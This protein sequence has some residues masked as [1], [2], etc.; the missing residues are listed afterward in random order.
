MRYRPPSK[1][2]LLTTASV[3]L[4]ASL[5]LAFSRP[6]EMRVDG[7]PVVSDVPPVTSVND[8]IFV[9][10][11]PVSDALG[12]ETHYQRKT[13]EVVVTRGDQSLRLRIGSTHA[14]ISGMPITLARAPFRVRG[15]I[16]L[17]LRTVE[18][19]FGVRAKFDRVSGRVEL[20]SPGVSSAAVR[21][22]PQ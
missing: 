11:R 13:G 15:R 5:A 18:Q 10:L 21:V 8:G 22:E 7:Q 9:P 12:S 2:G 19:A 1:G 17:S 16:M 3:A 20:A 6:I 4:L 14:V